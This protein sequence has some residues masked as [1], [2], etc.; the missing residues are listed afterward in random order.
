MLDIPT[1]G[2]SVIADFISMIENCQLLLQS[3]LLGGLSDL[4]DKLYE[5]SGLKYE[6]LYKDGK[7]KM[8]SL[9]NPNLIY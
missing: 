2:R 8:I 9:K 7:K 5:L 4:F 3:T 6:Y 1:K